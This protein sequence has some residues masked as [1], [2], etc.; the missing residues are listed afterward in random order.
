MQ[1]EDVRFLQYAE[2]FSP[3]AKF[4]EAFNS[5]RLNM[6]FS[7]TLL[8]KTNLEVL[9]KMKILSNISNIAGIKDAKQ[10]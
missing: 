2:I 1:N 8:A 4:F 10:C 5:T 9:L 6:L 7:P 3:H